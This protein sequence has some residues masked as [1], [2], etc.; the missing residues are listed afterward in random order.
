MALFQRMKGAPEEGMLTLC[1]S[2]GRTRD[3]T[4]GVYSNV[5]GWEAHILDALSI[6]K[7]VIAF[8]FSA[9]VAA[10]GRHGSTAAR[11]MTDEHQVLRK[12][13]F[14]FEPH[15]IL[16]AKGYPRYRVS[17]FAFLKNGP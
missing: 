10:G 12:T 14:F 9:I 7:C 8:Y 5:H 1:H 2:H 11:A 4:T 6:E 13:K 3:G 17:P 15:A 16:R